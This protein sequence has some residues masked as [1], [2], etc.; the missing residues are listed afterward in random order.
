L[1]ELRLTQATESQDYLGVKKPGRSRTKVSLP[2]APRYNPPF[3]RF[4]CAGFLAAV[5]ASARKN[6]HHV[7]FYAQFFRRKSAF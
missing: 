7:I 6:T 1:V 5:T 3:R 4:A 2:G